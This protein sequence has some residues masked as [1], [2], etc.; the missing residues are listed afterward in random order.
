MG[1]RD[2]EQTQFVKLKQESAEKFLKFLKAKLP[3]ELFLDRRIKVIHEGAYVLFPLVD[4]VEKVKMLIGAIS[5][6]LNFDI[7]SA[8]GVAEVNY[9]YRSIEE[10]LV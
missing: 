1:K 7:V 6:L 8:E 2:K 10:I 9:K 5:N 4:D 3:N